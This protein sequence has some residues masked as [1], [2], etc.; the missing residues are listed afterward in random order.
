LIVDSIYEVD[1]SVVTRRLVNLP[2]KAYQLS[3]DLGADSV[4]ELQ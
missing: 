1:L 4:I 2:G 3:A